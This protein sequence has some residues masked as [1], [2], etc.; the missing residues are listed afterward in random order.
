MLCFATPNG[1]DIRLPVGHEILTLNSFEKIYPRMHYFGE[2]V[3]P[4]EHTGG[5]KLHLFPNSDFVISEWLDIGPDQLQAA[6]TFAVRG[7]CLTLQ[8]SKTR[9]GQESLK[10]RFSDLHLQWGSIQKEGY[11]T[12]FEVFVFFG[13][14]W[15]KLKESSHE[16]RYMQRKIEY[17]DWEKILR[18]YSEQKN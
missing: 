8:F 3:F 7:D 6:G 18:D 16:V 4:D 14:E 5:T 15:K 12:G 17:N 1:A 11:V 13:Q 9:P 10:N 2:Y